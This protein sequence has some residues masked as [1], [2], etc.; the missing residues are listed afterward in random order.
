MARPVKDTFS[1]NNPDPLLRAP[2]GHSLTKP[3]G[4]R[5]F[6]RK[7]GT[8]YTTVPEYMDYIETKLMSPAIIENLAESMISGLSIR[9]ITKMIQL[10][11]FSTG[12]ANPDVLE[13]A[14]L[15]IEY[16]LAAMADQLDIP[17]KWYPTK[18]GAMPSGRDET[19]DPSKMEYMRR[20][21]PQAYDMIKNNMGKQTLDHISRKVEQRILAREEETKR[22]QLAEKKSS[23]FLGTN[24]EA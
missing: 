10:Q 14:G 9:E 2:P 7:G 16:Q 15:Q 12:M 20:N 1:R 8:K 23:G 17:A 3:L 22:Q 6:D 4:S 19:I 5:P 18:D 21:N 13:V 24:K 11:D